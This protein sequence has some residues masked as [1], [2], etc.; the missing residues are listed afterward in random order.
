MAFLVGLSTLGVRLMEGVVVSEALACKS[1]NLRILSN[2]GTSV[3]PWVCFCHSKRVEES[4]LSWII[5]VTP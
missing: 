5:E 4:N 1:M 2:V 3:V